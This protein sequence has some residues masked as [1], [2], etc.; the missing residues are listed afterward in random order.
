MSTH[1]YPWPLNG[2]SPRYL[3]RRFT[4]QHVDL[5]INFDMPRVDL[6]T[7]LLANCLL[8]MDGNAVDT[9]LAW[10]LSVAE[11]LQGLLAIAYAA[12]GSSTTAVANCNNEECHGDVELELGLSSFAVETPSK[13]DWLSPDK[14]NVSCRL[15][16][17][18]DQRAWQKHRRTQGM[19][20]VAWFANR[21]VEQIDDSTPSPLPETW[22][23]PIAAALEAADPL[24]ALNIDTM[25]PFCGKSLCVEVDLELLLIEGLRSQQRHLLEQIHRLAGRYHWSEADIMAMPLW[26]RQRYLSRLAAEVE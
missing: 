4:E 3:S 18:N 10:D 23:D 13:I 1:A 16:T 19:T 8:Q 22:L 6:V 12:V 11:R 2:D 20:D 14:K 5:D 7:S 25:C 24:T 15:P 9:E 17:G 21:L 26:R